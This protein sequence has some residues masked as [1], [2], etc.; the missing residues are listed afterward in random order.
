MKHCPSEKRRKTLRLDVSHSCLELFR[1][2]HST[3]SLHT[4]PSKKILQRPGFPCWR[5]RMIHVCLQPGT[6]NTSDAI[7][8][9]L[10]R[11]RH[12]VTRG[13]QANEVFHG[14]VGRNHEC[15]YFGNRGRGDDIR[16]RWRSVRR[17]VADHYVVSSQASDQISVATLL[18]R[19][20]S[21]FRRI[22]VCDG[23]VR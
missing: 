16:R 23:S 22:P 18:V 21:K 17:R 4:G 10:R 9:S 15:E 6:R 2:Q 13:F 19:L 7:R 1:S 12:F 5:H 8:F 11:V 14:R 20:C 3:M